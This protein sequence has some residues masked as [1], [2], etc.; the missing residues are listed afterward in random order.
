MPQAVAATVVTAVAR[1]L[2]GPITAVRPGTEACDV[3]PQRVDAGQAQ[4][5][6]ITREAEPAGTL[7]AVMSLRVACSAVRGLQTASIATGV[8]SHRC[9]HEMLYLPVRQYLGLLLSNSGSH[10]SARRRVVSCSTDP[11]CARVNT[12]VLWCG[13]RRPA[14]SRARRKASFTASYVMHTDRPSEPLSN[15]SYL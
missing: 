12:V 5:H 13:W 14:L 3:C 10:L 9:P 1:D 4:R 11:R 8:H 2:T 7:G 6:V 15:I